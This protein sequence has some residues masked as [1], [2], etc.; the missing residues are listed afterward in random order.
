MNE[1]KQ[2]ELSSTISVEDLESDMEMTIDNT[3]IEEEVLNRQKKTDKLKSRYIV[4]LT[5]IW[6]LGI[7]MVISGK[8]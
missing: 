4:L 5:L 7:V 1:D 8:I 3:K 6:T 2:T